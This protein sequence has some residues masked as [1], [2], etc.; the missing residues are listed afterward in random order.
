MVKISRKTIIIA[1][2]GV[3]HNNNLSKINKMIESASKI[4]AD[5]IK[6]QS[7]I[8]ENLIIKNTPKVNYQKKN[9]KENES[10]FSMLKK[11]ELSSKVYKTIFDKCKKKRIKPLFS[12]FD[13]DSFNFLR[14]NFKINAVKIASGEITN[15]PLLKNIAKTN[16]DIILSTGMASEREIK[17]SINLLKKNGLKEKKISILH[18]T[19]EYPARNKS[20]NLN[21][22]KKLKKD[23]K[24]RIGYS[25]HTNDIWT[26]IIAVSLG[27]E[28][29]E[30]HLT[31]S[32]L[33]KGPDQKASLNVQ[34]FSK[35]INMIKVTE[36][37]L[38]SYKKKISLLENKT[39][40]L[41]RKSIYSK[42]NII[43][44]EILNSK[45]MLTLRPQ[46]GIS[47]FFW[48]KMLNKKAKKNYKKF[49]KI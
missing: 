32:N 14:K 23:Y 10:Q 47:S 9:T 28:I 44:G 38:R 49:Q 17:D 8:T 11:Y 41:V 33:L 4:G 39:K 30:K 40:V 25:D 18:C 5:Y 31:L 35:M 45:N 24:C 21:F 46:T 16:I 15:Y 7:Y 13:N 34:N 26:P 3:N 22:I 36:E 19:S 1:E 42:K 37:K 2:A 48:E 27:A 12:V 6:F 43:K 29:I 20:L